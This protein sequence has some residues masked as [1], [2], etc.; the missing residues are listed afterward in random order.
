MTNGAPVW[1]LRGERG[2][3]AVR[4]KIVVG[5]ALAGAVALSQFGLFWGLDVWAKKTL[6]PNIAFEQIYRLH[7]A[8][9]DLRGEFALSANSRYLAWI[10]GGGLYVEDLVLRQ[11]CYAGDQSVDLFV[12]LADRSCLVFVADNQLFS[13]DLAGE[14]R[15]QRE[16]EAELPVPA[17]T[18]SQMAI[19]TYGNLIYLLGA[20][21]EG[22][23]DVFRIDLRK[24]REHLEKQEDLVFSYIFAANK[25]GALMVQAE[26]GNGPRLLYW[27]GDS[28]SAMVLP[29]LGALS[30]DEEA[31]SG[32]AVEGVRDVLL[33]ADDKGFYVG[34]LEQADAGADVK[35]KFLFRALLYYVADE[36]GDFLAP[37]VLW[38]GELPASTEFLS[39]ATGAGLL[40]KTEDQEPFLLKMVWGANQQIGSTLWHDLAVPLLSEAGSEAAVRRVFA[41]NGLTYLE[42]KGDAYCWRLLR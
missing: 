26:S 27:Q 37:A 15:L 3:K 9:E 22:G 31:A 18:Y 24:T 4:K 2:E 19:S 20:M 12:W 35:E 32:W 21:P 6:L 40:G 30:V 41:A 28:L 42:I 14:V 33:G 38:Q 23:Q 16:T 1:G 39:F 29:T 7:G 34:R 10:S 36:E 5:I 25:T 13:L 8:T 17:Y 11:C